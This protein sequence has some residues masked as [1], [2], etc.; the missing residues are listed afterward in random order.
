MEYK[1]YYKILGVDKTIGKEE[2]KKKYRKLAR[3][4]HPDVNLTD[5]NAAIKFGE[6]SEAYEVLSDV[7][8]RKKYDAISADWERQRT[9]GHEKDFDWS[10]YADPKNRRDRNSTGD[11]EDIFGHD[12][13]S[14]DFFRNIFRQGFQSRDERHY[15][16]KGHDY[17]AELSLSLE[18]AYAGGSKV[19]TVG[20]RQIRLTLKPGIRDRQTIMIKG[21]G[22][23][24]ING[25]ENGDLYLT[26]SLL[27][28]PD[29][30]I[31]GTDLFMDIP[32]SI[33]S[34]LLGATME[35]KT[36]SGKFKL[37]IPPETKNKAFL[38]LKG[39]GY[40]LYEKPG[41]SGDLYLRVILQLPEKL[42]EKE[43]TLIR[44]LAAL[45]N[46]KVAEEMK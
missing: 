8:K 36:I 11:W 10:R 17:K 40:P 21:K 28:N 27:P 46:E 4:Y 14:S 42:T 24:G 33:Y 7:E 29:Y 43:K 31:E 1:D 2:L 13:G 15:S 26:M 23:P 22:A 34:A 19:I 3:D 9:S 16:L 25:G 6:I 12:P 32:V 45:R 39:K 37:K 44:E 30:R 18:D 41:T 38:K 20:E 5:K 35:I